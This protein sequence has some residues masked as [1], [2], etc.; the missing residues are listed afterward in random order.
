MLYSS[1]QS[2]WVDELATPFCCMQVAIK[3]IVKIQLFIFGE[4]AASLPRCVTV[5]L[6][7]CAECYHTA[8]GI[9]A[10]NAMTLTARAFEFVVVL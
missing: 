10:H 7:A 4:A 5:D 2:A 9:P 1:W 6:Y 3:I 8:R